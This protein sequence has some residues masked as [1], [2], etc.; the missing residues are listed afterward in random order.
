[1]KRIT[2]ILPVYNEEANLKSTYSGLHG[3]ADS[4]REY[5]WTFLFVN[6]GSSD[7]SLEVLRSLREG[8]SR[9]NILS[10]SRNFGKENA[11]LAGMDYCDADAAIIMDSDGQHSLDVVPEM[12]GYWEE[13]YE[14]IYAMRR[15]RDTDSRVRRS[16]SRLYYRLLARISDTLV[17]PGAGDFRLLD[18]RC[19]AAVRSLRESNRYTKG[20]FAWIGFRKKGI[21]YNV[22]PREGGKSSFSY[23]SLL[24]LA[25]DGITSSTTFPLKLASLTGIIVS[26]ISFVYLIWVLVKTIM[27]GD[28]VQGFP[29]LICVILFMG[30]LQ[31]LSLGV[32]GEY[33]G[34]IFTESKRRPPY[35][36]DSLNGSKIMP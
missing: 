19:V 7:G 1:M 17:L 25:L 20:L 21:Y 24:R 30:G 14:D 4:L 32:I 2:V 33:V 5:D 22:A 28:P 36:A 26:L 23:V 35:I 3:L 11:M 12:I 27:W 8:D 34:R 9:V 16:L 29:T 10:L 18:R 13:D 6:D 15:S 31:L